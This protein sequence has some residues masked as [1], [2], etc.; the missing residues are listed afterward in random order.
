MKRQLTVP[1]HYESISKVTQLVVEAA[2]Q[3]GLDERAIFHCQ[4]AVDEACTNIVEHAYAD[5]SQGDIHITI[6]VQ[7]GVCTITLVDYGT[8]FD[9][10]SIPP[11]RIDPD[12]AKMEPGGLGL[13]LMR[14][15]MDEVHFS[16]SAGENRLVMI[17]RQSPSA[18]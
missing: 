17:K 18:E 7:E 1:A 8:S 5:K 13:H 12:P 15:L 3:A 11:P 16:F 4:M 9:P 6:Q 2:A 14:E 10:D